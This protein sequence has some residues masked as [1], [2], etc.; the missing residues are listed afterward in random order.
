MRVAILSA[1]PSLLRTWSL[2]LRY[3]S[4]IAV[5]SA[6]AVVS[7]DWLAAGDDVTFRR[8]GAHRPRV[9]CWTVEDRVRIPVE[10]W[11]NVRALAWEGMP[12]WTG[13]SRKPNWSVQAALAG[14]Y[15]LGATIVDVYG[16]DMAGDA[17]VIGYIG[18][19]RGEEH[20]WSR[21]RPDWQA[22]LTW[23]ADHGLTVNE[24]KG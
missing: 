17:D 18:D 7:A 24:I 1:G 3:A 11:A 5:N 19:V 12:G 15:S 2:D 23:A 14:A 10:G 9:G 22:S 13:L 6:L 8:L 20:R 16:H 21:E 4:T